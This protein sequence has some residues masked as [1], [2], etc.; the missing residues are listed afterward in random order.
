MIQ[1]VVPDTMAKS[2]AIGDP[3]DGRWAAS[4]IRDTGGWAAVVD[5]D[6]IAPGIT[7]LAQHTGLFT[8]PAGGVTVSGARLLANQARLTKN[9]E[10]VLCLTG[11]GLKTVE[12]LDDTL[13]STPVIDPDIRQLEAMIS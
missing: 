5:E 3:V 13:E 7:L 2:I 12:V 4:A 8:E 11:N 6:D 1:S 10:V 9:D